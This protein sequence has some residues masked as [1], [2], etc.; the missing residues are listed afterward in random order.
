VIAVPVSVKIDSM[1]LYLMIK[2][3]VIL[4]VFAI[5]VFEAAFGLVSRIEA[6]I[7]FLSLFIAVI[8]AVVLYASLR[9]KVLFEPLGHL[10]ITVDIIMIYVTIYFNGGV[11][12]SWLFLPPLVIFLAAYMFD[13]FAGVAFALFSYALL[14]LMAYLQYSNTL[15]FH[16]LFNLPQEHWRNAKYLTDYLAG[17]FAYYI[18]AAFSVG[19]LTRL[20]AKRAER[21][22]EFRDRLE[23]AKIEENAI[24]EKMRQAKVEILVKNA[25]IE[26]FQVYSSGRQLKLIDLRRKLEELKKAA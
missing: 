11:E 12:N 14:V 22:D 2:W 15:P 13:I 5:N 26:R 24:K 17:S 19:T 9:K 7:V 20:A 16:P 23:K 8:P 21:A 3:L 4:L 25:E 6:S 18:L 1:R 10:S